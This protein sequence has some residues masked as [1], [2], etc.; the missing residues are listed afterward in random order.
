MNR[1]HRFVHRSA[2]LATLAIAACAPAERA[3]TPQPHPADALPPTGWTEVPLLVGKGNLFEVDAEIDS[4][5]VVLLLDSGASW[6]VID[7][8]SAKRLQLPLQPVNGTV[9]GLGA[10]NMS[11]YVTDLK[12]VRLGQ[13][14]AGPVSARVLDLS[15]VN[16]SRVQIGDRPIDGLIGATYF[17]DYQAVIN[18]PSKKLYL[19][20]PA[21]KSP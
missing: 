11:S 8:T 15:A 19:R 7:T 20:N 6:L 4:T 1:L 21:T 3:K 18:Y 2:L 13:F 14:S 17:F 12:N 10:S 5:P 16:Q 9:G